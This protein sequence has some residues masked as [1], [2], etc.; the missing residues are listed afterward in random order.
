MK[1]QEK[2]MSFLQQLKDYDEVKREV[3]KTSV[4]NIDIN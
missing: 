3:R 4:Q 2:Y 1:E